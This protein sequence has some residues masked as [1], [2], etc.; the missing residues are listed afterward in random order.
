MFP[1][2]ISAFGKI[3]IPKP[4]AVR[5]AG[6]RCLHMAEGGYAHEPNA[7]AV[8]P[9]VNAPPIEFTEPMQRLSYDVMR[10]FGPNITPTQWTR[11][12]DNNAALTNNQGFGGTPPRR[13]YI[14]GEAVSNPNSELPKLM[15]AILFSGTFIHA[16]VVGSLLRLVPGVH[17]VDATKPMPSAETVVANNWYTFAVSADMQAASHFIAGTPT[18]VV[19]FLREAVTFPAAW[20]ERWERDV[21]PNPTTFYRL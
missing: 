21:L 10:R 18:A 3:Y 16:D 8:H 11:V 7:P 13:N 17:A 9:S 4:P 15:K 1:D 5:Y 6:Y 2:S 19:Y 20:F 12:F 14:T